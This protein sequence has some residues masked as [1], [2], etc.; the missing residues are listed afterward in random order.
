MGQLQQ[1]P[2]YAKAGPP[3]EGLCRHPP[4]PQLNW[5]VAPPC[6]VLMP[7]NDRFDRTAQVVMV[8]FV[9]RPALFE[10]RGPNRPLRIRQNRYV[11]SLR[12]A[13]GRIA[14]KR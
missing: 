13:G 5:D 2:P 1:V 10:Q 9:G 12:Q 14:L 4:R 6:L 8:G 7:P 11:T 3:I